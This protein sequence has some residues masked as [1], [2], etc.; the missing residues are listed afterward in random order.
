[1]GI[2][3]AGIGSGLDVN[4]IV[5]SLMAIEQ[6][7]L[8]AVTKQKAAYQAKISA[9][10]SLSSAMSNF[11]DKV[12]ALSTPSA[13]NPQ[14]VSSTDST[15]VTAT[16]SGTAT[17]GSYALTVSQLAKSQVLVSPDVAATDTAIGTGNLNITFGTYSTGVNSFTPNNA[18]AEISI[19]ID[20]TNNTLTGVRDAINAANA[21]IS[22]KI[23]NNGTS[24]QLV[25]TSTSTGEINS[26]KISVTDSDGNHQDASGLSQLAFDPTAVNGNGKN[27]TQVQATQNAHLNID[28]IDIVK[29]SNNISE[30]IGGVTL[31]LLAIN[32]NPVNVSVSTNQDQ[33][34]SSISAFVDGYHKLDATLRG[35]TKFAGAGNTSGVLLD[36]ATARSAMAQIKSMMTKVMVNSGSLNSLNQIGISFQSS[37]QL[38]L[39]ATKLNTAISTR[40]SDISA[41]FASSAKASDAKVSY[42]SSSSKTQAG[43]YAVTVSNLSPLAGTINGAIAVANG[44]TLLGAVGDASEGLNLNVAGGGLGNRG[45]V[46]FSLGYASQL[47]RIATSLLGTDGLITSRTN[48]IKNSIT[49]LDKEAISIQARLTK[50]EARYRTQY[51]Q[52]DT[53]MSSMSSTSSTLTQ[54]IASLNANNTKVA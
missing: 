6:K 30:V 53:M 34:K 15:V 29:P 47:N 45:T 13:F 25:I 5:T 51:T 54:Q 16:A 49:R 8:T 36:D 41:L 1:M 40:L 28:G 37:G 3:S 26:L 20:S 17:I 52:L 32:V 22:A 42:V 23:V 38:A 27:M 19:N 48:G 10:G 12:N 14:S 18:K 4:G 7:P 39:D 9:F 31:N 35:L 50:I 21:D 43:T 33:I 2:S 44:T 24:N 11:Q 46:S